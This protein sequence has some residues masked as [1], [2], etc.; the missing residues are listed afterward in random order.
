MEE[1]Y[2][3]QLKVKLYDQDLM[4]KAKEMAAAQ[5]ELNKAEDEKSQAVSSLNATIKGLRAKVD[6]LS[7]AITNGYELRMVDCTIM[8]DTPR[9]GMKTIIRTDSGEEVRQELMTEFD[10]QQGLDLKPAAE[11]PQEVPPESRAEAAE[12]RPDPDAE[13]PADIH[14]WLEKQWRDATFVAPEYRSLL[15]SWLMEFD[16][17]PT[18]EQYHAWLEEQTGGSSEA[19]AGGE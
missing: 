6:D 15:E 14:A 8:F 2:K 19:A 5:Q 1:T 12:A 10:R 17:P 11:E 4:V 3:E 13:L 7:V 9:P 16:G 18:P